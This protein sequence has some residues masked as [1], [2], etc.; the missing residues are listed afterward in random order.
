MVV[1]IVETPQTIS[2]GPNYCER[3]ILGAL[4]VPV[5]VQLSVAGLYRP[6][7]LKCARRDIHQT[8]FGAR[9]HFGGPSRA[10]SLNCGI[11]L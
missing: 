1:I 8:T 7:V 3:R 2:A 10:S 4:V 6:P 5:S 11:Q 9:P